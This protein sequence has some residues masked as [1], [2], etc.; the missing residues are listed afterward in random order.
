MVSFYMFLDNFDTTHNDATILQDCFQRYTNEMST[1]HEGDTILV[2]R[3]FC[4]VLNIL[5]EEKNLKARELGPLNTAEAHASRCVIKC[6]WV[7]EQVF[8][9]LKKKF[10]IFSLPAHNTTLKHDLDSFYIAFVLLNLFH[11]PILSDVLHEDIAQTLKSRLNVSNRSQ[12]IVQ[13]FNLP[14]LTRG[15]PGSGRTDFLQLHICCSI[16]PQ[17]LYVAHDIA[18]YSRIR[19]KFAL[20]IFR[21]R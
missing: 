6:R 8:G 5:T 18:T 3:G 11:K 7:I 1:I 12:I 20:Q 17:L 2:D 19:E 21:S 9:R 13:E 15:T 14:Q 10:K 16:N 4:D